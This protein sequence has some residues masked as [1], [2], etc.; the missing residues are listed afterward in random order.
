[1]QGLVTHPGWEANYVMN[2]DLTWKALPAPK[3]S[4]QGLFKPSGRRSP[5]VGADTVTVNNVH[6]GVRPRVGE[7]HWTFLRKSGIWLNPTAAPQFTDAWHRDYTCSA[8]DHRV[9]H[10]MKTNGTH[11]SHTIG[12]RSV[13]KSHCLRGK[14]SALNIWLWQERTCAKTSRVYLK[15]S[16]A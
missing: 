3:K 16:S 5:L 10:L 15:G 13:L 14:C 12:L 8:T 6:G 7:H 11:R 9:S 2:L 4:S 1:M